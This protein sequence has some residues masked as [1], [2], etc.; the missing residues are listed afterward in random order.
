MEICRNIAQVLPRLLRPLFRLQSGNV[1]TKERGLYPIK[2][3]KYTIPCSNL[4]D[5]VNRSPENIRNAAC[6]AEY[7]HFAYFN[8]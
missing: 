2:R 3:Y 1:S 5:E 7:W 8:L 6:I 4:F